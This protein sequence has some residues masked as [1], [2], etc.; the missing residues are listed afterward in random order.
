LRHA[1]TSN[2]VAEIRGTDPVLKNEYLVIGA[3]YDHLGMGGPGSGSRQPDTIAVHNGADDN[4][5]GV[6]AVLELAEALEA[7]RKSLKRSVLFVLFTA[8]EMGTL[9]SKYFVDNP[10]V[11]IKQIKYMINLDMVGRMKTDEKAISIGGTGTAIGMEELLNKFAAG[12][13][14]TVKMNPEGYGP[15]DHASF[16]SKDIPV[17]FFMAGMHE[18]YHTPRD[19]ANRLNYGGEKAIAD[20]ILDVAREL[21]NRTDA[22]AF[23]EAGPKTQPQGGRRFKVTFGIMPDFTSSNVKGV[24]AEVVMPNRPASRA[25]M[26]KGDIIVSIEGKPVND[27]YEY[28]HRLGELRV[29]DRVSV[30]VLRDGKKEILIV[31]L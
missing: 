13:D 10:I 26:K 17:L 20:Y 11:S 29:G 31:E 6:A 28:M 8:E 16:Y 9:G 22:M 25:G 27:I 1:A 18:D 2:V 30:E 7:E 12:R 21:D 4:A 5:S 14:F 23:K 3:H 24:R 15:S 19:D